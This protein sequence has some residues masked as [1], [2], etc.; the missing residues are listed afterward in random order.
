MLQTTR[1]ELPIVQTNRLDSDYLQSLG[2]QGF[3]VISNCLDSSG[4]QRITNEIESATEENENP[5]IR[6]RRSVYAI[7]NLFEIAPAILDKKLQSTLRELVKPVLG[8]KARL[9]RGILFDKTEDANWGVLWHQDLSIA[10]R[11]REQVNEFQRWSTKS[12]VTHVQPPASILEKMLTVRL[13]LDECLEENGALQ[14]IPG[15]H[16]HGRL[17][18]SQVDQLIQNQP[19]VACSVPAGGAVIMRVRCKNSAES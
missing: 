13:H 9:V 5:A 7:R 18:S 8:G 10:V 17:I 15:S 4:I 2:E 14:V 16:R 1:T 19:R 12:G 6:Q 11:R 3:S